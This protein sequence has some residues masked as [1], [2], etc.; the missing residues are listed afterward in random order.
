M[1]D[2]P[3]DPDATLAAMYAAR[4][5]AASPMQASARD[6]SNNY[7]SSTMRDGQVVDTST[8]NVSRTSS[9][10]IA[11]EANRAANVPYTRAVNSRGEYVAPHQVTEDTRITLPGVG[12]VTVAQAKSAGFLP[13][14]WSATSLNLLEQS[15][16]DKAREEAMNTPYTANDAPKPETILIWTPS[17]YLIPALSRACL[18]L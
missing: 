10:A 17:P 2:H 18:S 5:P 3:K 14:N 15:R 1:T 13:Y 8:G 9:E 7:A 4:E 11:S 12:E 16:Q 6:Y